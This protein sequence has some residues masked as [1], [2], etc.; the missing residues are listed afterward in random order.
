MKS[1]S[2]TRLIRRLLIVRRS[3]SGQQVN[4]D[5]TPTPAL[6]AATERTS[7]CVIILLSIIGKLETGI[8]VY[9]GAWRGRKEEHSGLDSIT[10]AFVWESF[11]LRSSNQQLDVRIGFDRFV[12]NYHNCGDKRQNEDQNMHV[13][14][15]S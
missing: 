15:R 2:E 12:I 3:G 8:G 1:A 11:V 7:I 9:M 5:L 4:H 13:F 10:A 6:A 14:S